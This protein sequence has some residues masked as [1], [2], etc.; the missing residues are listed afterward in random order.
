MLVSAIGLTSLT[1]VRVQARSE[2]AA[3][4]ASLARTYARSSIESAV[5]YTLAEPDWRNNYATLASYMPMKLDRGSCSI[6]V[7][8][9][10]GSTLIANADGAVLLKGTGVVGA[11]ASP[12]AIYR[13]S[14]QAYHPPLDLLRTAL[15][16]NGNL[17][18]TST[19]AVEDGPLSTNATLANSGSIQ[20]DV[21]A[22][23]ISNWGSILGQATSNAAT[24]QMTDRVWQYY[25]G[26]PGLV[27]LPAA[28]I[29]SALEWVVLSPNSNPWE[30][31]KTHADGLYRIQPSGDLRIRDCRILGTLIVELNAGRKLYL[32]NGVLWEPA[33]A[34][35]P[36]LIVNGPVE[37]RL[38][39]TL[40]ESNK[41]NFNPSSTP[42]EG[43]SD[44]DRSDTYPSVLKGVFHV[45]GSSSTLLVENQ[46][47]VQGVLICDG[48][49]TV[50]GTG[51]FTA[52]VN[53]MLSP[54]IMY[55]MRHLELETGTWQPVFGATGP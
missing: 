55:R 11:W 16:V 43:V 37:M 30:P 18:V 14:V 34:D 5:A 25:R 33:R 52:D 49:A 46:T 9:V 48:S 44:T 28:T 24:K 20:G 13:W 2:Q 21:E 7:T 45:V 8:E 6:L 32:E 31:A 36:S 15:H 26:R 42:Y 39:S 23:S 47:R 10:D 17:S 35:Y 53:L 12:D 22:K 1:L 4:H 40:Y 19:V 50:R 27:T 41:T 29:G 3:I 38:G 54:P 51:P